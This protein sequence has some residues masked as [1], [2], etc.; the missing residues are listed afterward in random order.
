MKFKFSIQDKVLLEQSCTHQLCAVYGHVT[1]A[2]QNTLG[3]R[4]VLNLKIWKYLFSGPFQKI[5]A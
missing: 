5:L 1:V 4:L 2:E 3:Q